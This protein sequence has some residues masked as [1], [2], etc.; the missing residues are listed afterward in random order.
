MVVVFATTFRRHT[1]GTHP[2]EFRVNARVRIASLVVVGGLALGS[3]A[4]SASDAEP[5]SGKDKGSL[6]VEA[7]P[8]E[9]PATIPVTTP[10]STTPEAGKKFIWLECAFTNCALQTPGIKDAAEALGWSVEVLPLSG[11]NP[12]GSLDTAIQKKPDFIGMSGIPAAAIQAQLDTAHAAGI[13]VISCGT[14]D[15]AA[16][17]GYAAECGGTLATDGNYIARWV[18]NDSGGDANAVIVN[19]P[20]Y[21][22]LVSAADSMKDTFADQCSSCTSDELDVTPDD[23]GAGAVSQ[24]VIAY[25]QTHPDTNYVMVTLSDLGV[26][27]PQVIKSAG[28]GDKVKV[29]GTV[30]SAAI[31]QGLASGDFAAWTVT[32]KP[33]EGATMID[34]A[35]RLSVGDELSA[36]YLKVIY[37]DPTWVVDSKESADSLNGGAWA[38]PEGFLDQYKTLWGVN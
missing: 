36:D 34:A 28:L 21:S 12:G 26:G 5:N 33:Y 23:I 15:E 19:I 37:S 25:L 14:L 17:D 30:D 18:I 3:S 20:Q 6:S 16:P 9:A 38:G 8:T 32:P 29:V 22:S 1:R 10:L 11:T 31:V 27:L 7:P 2:K 4:C 13:P 24:K 35:A